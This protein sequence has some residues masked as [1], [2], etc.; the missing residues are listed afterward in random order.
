LIAFFTIKYPMYQRYMIWGG[1]LVCTLA[2]VASSFATE[3]WHLMIAQGFLYGFG[4]LTM[5]YPLL[6]MLNE[7]FVKRRGL[8]YGI[9]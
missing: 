7:W 5:Y 1:W 3:V 9:L 6:N 4:F 8:A 2:L